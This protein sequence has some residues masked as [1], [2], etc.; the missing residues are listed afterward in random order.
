MKRVLVVNYHEI[1]KLPPVISLL[2]VLSRNGY[3]LSVI[4]FDKNN[5]IDEK[6]LNGGILYRLDPSF[7]D[8]KEFINRKI[9]LR[10]LV[11]KLMKNNDILWTT[12]DRTVRELADTVLNY[13]H[14]MQL[15]ELIE[16]IPLIPGQNVIMSHLY[17]YGQKAYKVVVPE[18]NRA[19][20]QKTWWRLD[21]LPVVL[22]NKPSALPDI[23]LAPDKVKDISSRIKNNNSK[24]IIYQGVIR[25]ERPLEEF[26]RAIEDFGGKYTFLIMGNDPYGEAERLKTK[27]KYTETINFI[28]PP[29]HLLIT[30]EC[31]AGILSY[32]PEYNRKLHQSILNALYCAPNKLYEY[33]GYNIPMIGNDVPGLSYPLR[34]Y[35]MGEICNLSDSSDVEQKIEKIAANRSDYI[36]GCKKF[37]NQINLDDIII[38]KILED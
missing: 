15:M 20:I 37:Y 11:V 23:S 3:I 27:Y 29:Y 6:K 38:K 30:K 1:S 19:H 10:K 22:P 21:K 35:H 9:K 4:S 28:N 33:S 24:T 17:K 12:T 8:P 14:V 36:S 25:K 16:D 7:E 2:N 26:S 13:K 31:F 34:Y 32:V 18:Y 5:I